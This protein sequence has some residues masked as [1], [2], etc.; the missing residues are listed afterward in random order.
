MASKSIYVRAKGV[1]RGSCENAMRKTRN[2]HDSSSNDPNRRREHHH[3]QRDDVLQSDTR[4]STRT[5]RKKERIISSPQ[6]RSLPETKTHAEAV[7]AVPLLVTCTTST[8]TF[9]SDSRLW[10]IPTLL[11][12][13]RKPGMRVEVV[14]KVR[15]VRGDL[16]PLATV[17]FPTSQSRPRS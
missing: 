13:G 6:P 17:A 11:L 4:S 5:A 3:L 2:R 15:F 8:A 16:V 10:L 9:P 7:V 14:E 1:Q 12:A